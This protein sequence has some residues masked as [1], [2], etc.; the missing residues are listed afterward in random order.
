[1]KN[2]FEISDTELLD[3][4][5]NRIIKLQEKKYI[6]PLDIEFWIKDVDRVWGEYTDRH[7]A[8]TKKY[9]EEHKK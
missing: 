4:L 1:M 3:I 5:I 6:H 2:D 8:Y 7:D 9:E